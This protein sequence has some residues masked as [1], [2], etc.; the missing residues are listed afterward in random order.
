MINETTLL[1]HLQRSIGSRLFSA[2]D[3]N[4]FLDILNEDTLYTW[5]SYYPK[6]VRGIKITQAC[7]IPTYDPINNQQEYHRYRIPKLNFEDEYVGIE[8]WMFN[9]QGYEQAYA[10]F[11]GPLA[12]AAISR[13]RS[14]L[15]IPAVRWRCT[16]E[17][18]DFVD[19]YPYRRSHQDF[20]LIM[21][22][23]VR[24]NEIPIGLQEYFKRLFVLDV[25][26]ALYNEFPAARE[27]GTINGIEVNTT[28]SD[29]SSADSD[30]TSLLETFDG[31]WMTN[32]DRFEALTSQS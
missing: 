20:V 10:G 12:D 25:K 16:F 27:S 14:L 29:F 4:Y 2:L 7:A 21:Q 28:I 30:R 19:V 1:R 8:K 5:S 13:V 15:P 23:K 26:R 9:G 11:N 24:L 32:P 3:V 22:R 18:P 6:L 31:D 17:A